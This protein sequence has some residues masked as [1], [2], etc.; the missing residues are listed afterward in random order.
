[1]VIFI[2]KSG[3]APVIALERKKSRK[4]QTS[5]KFSFCYLIVAVI[6]DQCIPW[7]AREQQWTDCPYFW[8]L[9][10]AL[11]PADAATIRSLNKHDLV[12]LKC[13]PYD[14]KNQRRAWEVNL[15]DKQRRGEL[16]C[17]YSLR[18]RNASHGRSRFDIQMLN[19]W[20]CRPSQN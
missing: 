11:H 7:P 6:R 14:R 16:F 12:K 8:A 3:K 5:E 1:M 17:T 4:Q 18:S 13:Q 9:K 2:P 20:V 19:G 10:L 15:D